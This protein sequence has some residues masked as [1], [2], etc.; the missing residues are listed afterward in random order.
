MVLGTTG[1]AHGQPVLVNGI[2]GDVALGAVPTAALISVAD[3]HTARAGKLDAALVQILISKIT[4]TI[5]SGP[6]FIVR[7][8]DPSDSSKV[9][10]VLVDSLLLAPHNI[11][12]IGLT[13]NV[14]GVLVPKGD[15]TWVLKPRGGGDVI[16]SQ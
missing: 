10:D 6:D 15:G 12:A 8:L 9:T 2:F 16:L 11:W 1:T 4:D 3:A 7:V 13:L 14:R 5:P